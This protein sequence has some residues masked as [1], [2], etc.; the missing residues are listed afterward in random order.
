MSFARVSLVE[1][2]KANKKNIM[3]AIAASIYCYASNDATRIF[4][5]YSFPLDSL[6]ADYQL[7]FA[8]ISIKSFNDNFILDNSSI[9][10]VDTFLNHVIQ[11]G[12][13][14]MIAEDGNINAELKHVLM[15]DQQVEVTQ[16]K[17]CQILKSYVGHIVQ[18]FKLNHAQQ[19]RDDHIPIDVLNKFACLESYMSRAFINKT[20][21]GILQSG[22]IYDMNYFPE[23]KSSIV[24][25][26]ASFFQNN[27]QGTAV[28]VS[29][30]G[31]ATLF[32][33]YHLA[34][35]KSQDLFDPAP[36]M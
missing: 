35:N 27:W 25:S 3:P 5:N 18:Y 14:D 9:L 21:E 2:F 10:T 16:E 11:R 34:A 1:Y 33:L 8:N 26:A 32:S 24:R 28:T 31:V 29:L 17:I 13:E 30:V 6:F 12:I 15:W 23:N 36:R 22:K 4:N 20:R 7:M 19:Y